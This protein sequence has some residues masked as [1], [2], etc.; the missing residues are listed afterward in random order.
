MTTLNRRF[1]ALATFV[2]VTLSP[3]EAPANAQQ[4]SRQLPQ[5]TSPGVVEIQSSDAGPV[6]AS[7]ELKGWEPFQ[8]IT[9]LPL[10]EIRGER[11][12]GSTRQILCNPVAASRPC[13]VDVIIDGTREIWFHRAAGPDRERVLERLPDRIVGD[14][15]FHITISAVAQGDP[16]S[17]VG[18]PLG[19]DIP[20]KVWI[21]NTGPGDV[22]HSYELPATN[23]LVMARHS[24]DADKLSGLFLTLNRESEPFYTPAAGFE[25]IAARPDGTFDLFAVPPNCEVL[26]ALRDTVICGANTR[27]RSSASGARQYPDILRLNLPD[28]THQDIAR[29][30]K[31]LAFRALDDAILIEGVTDGVSRIYIQGLND[32]QAQPA[33]VDADQCLL[34]TQHV[35]LFDLTASREAVMLQVNGP[36][37]PARLVLAPIIDDR[38]HICADA[39]QIYSEQATNIEDHSAYSIERLRSQAAGNV[40]VTLVSGPESGELD[41]HLLMVTYAAYGIFL[42][43]TYLG[44]WLTHW[45]DRGGKLAFVH[46]PGGGGY[47]AQWAQRGFGIQRKLVTSQMFDQV[48]ADLIA[49][50]HG[51]A[52]KISV[53]TESAGGPLAA[54]AILRNPSRY[55]AFALRAAC[56]AIE[57]EARENCANYYGYGNWYDPR[58]QQLM[59]DFEPLDQIIASANY[60]AIIYG[61][62]ETDS[63]L[64]LDYQRRMADALRGRDMVVFDLP[65]VEHTGRASSEVEDQW[66][67]TIADAALRKGNE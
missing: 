38:I 32:R 2:A 34:P 23:Q 39:A 24:Y 25:L 40:P 44:P 6:M 46:L 52:G 41:G 8:V 31:S 66:V 11:S 18:Q 58:D 67:R 47:G 19:S 12:S 10:R 16:L 62:P 54:H 26:G 21:E 1:L 63:V 51:E 42:P 60:P 55:A 37:S 43:E 56:I 45:V 4:T 33:L 27:G 15:F 36:L 49:L 53:M 14:D 57:G 50:G 7:L 28:G 20:A 9:D 22:F 13:L 48:S 61:I 59:E 30:G 64:S 3:L 29:D 35:E 17:F 65:G 5:N